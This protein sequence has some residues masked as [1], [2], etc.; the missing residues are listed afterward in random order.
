MSLSGHLWTI[1]RYTLFAARPPALPPAE[2]WATELID[3]TAGRLT[4]TGRL[5]PEGEEIVLIVHGLGGCADS[6]YVPRA[7]AAAVG[8]GLASLALNVRGADR[9]G[10]DYGH[11]AMTADLVA[12]IA[13]PELA[14][15]SRIRLLGF[16]LGGHLALRYATESPDARVAAVAAVCA[17]LD[18]GGCCTYLD[19][20]VGAIYRRHLLRRLMEIYAAVAAHSEVPV[21]V[22]EAQRIRLQREFDGR[23]VAP[24]HGFTDVEDYYRRA[25]VGPRLDR[26]RVPALLVAAEG[27][28]IVP[29]KTLLPFLDPQPPGLTVRWVAGGHVGFP[30][31]LDLG[32]AAPL[33]LEPQV[34]SWL[35]A[36]D[37][38]GTPNS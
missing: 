21:P 33:G 18:L 1:A 24:R 19:R 23:I 7:E 20:P 32:E 28:P 2:S 10:G 9:A 16:S 30:A 31:R 12:A 22:E 25:S 15:Y 14:H 38:A 5:R 8:A 35:A 26:L 37:P 17:P 3:P 11:A 4:L 34:L 36:I 6:G 13:S 27:D 29:A